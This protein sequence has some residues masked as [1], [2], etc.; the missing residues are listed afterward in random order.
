MGDEEVKSDV[1]EM[2]KSFSFETADGEKVVVDDGKKVED[3]E[4][5]KPIADPEP[6]PELDSDPD[7]DPELKPEPEPE[8]DPNLELD[9]DPEPEL[10]EKDKV[11][12]ELR[13]KLDEKE[14][15]PEPEPEPEESLKF[16]SQEFIDKDE[17]LE[18]LIRDPGKLNEVFNKV[19]QRAVTDTRKVLGEGVL[20]S[21]PDIVRA[22]VDMMDKLKQMNTKFYDDNKDLKPFQ[23]VVAAVFEEVA[24]DNPGK[25]MMDLLPMVAKD[26]RKRLELHKQA[27]QTDDKKLPRL[28]RRK[29][30]TALLEDKPET[31]PLLNELKEMNKIIRR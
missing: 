20:R 2:N 1:Q 6:E 19:Y 3:V 28:P 27:T 29:R 26:A 9:S 24:T 15:D 22:S 23:K 16:E 5:D 11:I 31:D 30:R 13:K 25:D 12:A 8:P 10:D 7:P 14:P 21:I 17:D 18:D 4:K